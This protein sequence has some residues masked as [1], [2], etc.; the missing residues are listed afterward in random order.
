MVA[1]SGPP[2]TGTASAT[3]SAIVKATFATFNVVVA[4]GATCDAPELEES[5]TS[6]LQH[7]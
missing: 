3:D 2:T 6:T 1:L 5:D 4:R 7:R